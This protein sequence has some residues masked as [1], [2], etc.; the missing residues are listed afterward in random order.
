[1]HP[2]ECGWCDY[3]LTTLTEMVDTFNQWAGFDVRSNTYSRHEVRVFVDLPREE[4]QRRI[5]AAQSFADP[6]PVLQPP[7]EP[8]HDEEWSLL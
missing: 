1:M 5:E 6:E 8:E 2:R 3:P 4:Q 7:P